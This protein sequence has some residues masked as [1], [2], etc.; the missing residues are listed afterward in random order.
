MDSFNSDTPVAQCSDV[1]GMVFSYLSSTR[2]VLSCALVCR[3][4]KTV[5][6]A[7]DTATPVLL[8]Y[9]SLR[10]FSNA[11]TAWLR[12]NIHRITSLK[13]QLV[14]VGGS[15]GSHRQDVLEL[16]P[17]AT[18][19]GHALQLLSHQCSQQQVFSTPPHAQTYYVQY[20]SLLWGW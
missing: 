3:A 1:L 8:P 11:H 2:D 7:E 17:A 5:I 18:A 12:H 14:Q 19:G 16:L 20:K 4:W 6:S 13:L 10:L 15:F 9:V